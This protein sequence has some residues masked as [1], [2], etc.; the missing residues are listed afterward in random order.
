MT[1]NWYLA[2]VHSNREAVVAYT[3]RCL[4]IEAFLPLLLQTER[5]SARTRQKEL[6]ARPALPGYLFFKTTPDRVTD[7]NAIRDLKGVIRS[8]MGELVTIPPRQMVPFIIAHDEWQVKAR[9]AY[10]G[11]LHIRSAGPKPKFRA[12]TK[13][14]LEEFMR[15]HFLPDEVNLVEAA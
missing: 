3:M 2:E 10:R 7:A 5:V 9:N 14:V 13:D 12:M 15:T 6:V 11:G 1:E 8:P 4:A